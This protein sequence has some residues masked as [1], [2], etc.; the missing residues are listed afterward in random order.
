MTGATA[1]PTATPIAG[2]LWHYAVP[3]RTHP[4]RWLV[5]HRVPG[6]DWW[7]SII[8]CPTEAAALA[9]AERRNPIVVP[10]PRLS[11]RPPAD[12]CDAPEVLQ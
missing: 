9:E 4:G 1:T 11:L 2:T 10:P 6:T 3:S 8:D 5:V 7:T 12:V